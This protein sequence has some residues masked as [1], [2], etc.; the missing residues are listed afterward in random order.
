MDL[1]DGNAADR[2]DGTGRGAAWNEPNERS[3]LA[4]P[5]EDV[6]DLSESPDV[7]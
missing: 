3:L 7:C 1:A 4:P 5:T 6:S 2:A